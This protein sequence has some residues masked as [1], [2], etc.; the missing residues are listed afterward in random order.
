MLFPF[1]FLDVGSVKSCITLYRH[2]V[3][4]KP[5]LLLHFHCQLSCMPI[6][7]FLF[8]STCK[9]DIPF[10]TVDIF[11]CFKRMIFFHKARSWQHNLNHLTCTCDDRFT[12][13]LGSE[14]RFSS[15]FLAPHL[16]IRPTR[17]KKN[18]STN[19]IKTANKI[20]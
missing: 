20:I 2:I 18:K 9:F 11:H 6:F 4:N 5:E 13:S 19:Q 3:F 8:C 10:W 15:G 14:L 7:Q 17:R 12:C 16:R 1:C